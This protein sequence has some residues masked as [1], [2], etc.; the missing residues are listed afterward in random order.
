[1]VVFDA[2]LTSFLP[3]VVGDKDLVASNSKLQLSYSA[4]SIVGPG[5]AGWLVQLATAPFA[6]LTGV[7]SLLTA[8]FSFSKIRVEE[9]KTLPPEQETVWRDVREGLRILLR[10]PILRA[11]SLPSC[12]SS[13]ALSVQQTVLI[14]FLLGSWVLDQW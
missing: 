2:A 6:I 7:G 12:L 11:L 1:M 4:S 8:A 13:F 14:L 9:V 5:I 3:A 10:S